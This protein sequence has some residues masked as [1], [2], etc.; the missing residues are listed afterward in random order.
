MNTKKTTLLVF[1]MMTA[2][3][4]CTAQTTE[5]IKDQG[6]ELT[7]IN[8]DARFSKSL[9]QMLVKTFFEVYPKLAKAF[10]PTTVKKVTFVI[11]TA[12]QGV[13]GTANGKVSYSAKYMSENPGDIDVVTHEVMHIVQD[14]GSS[15]GPW[16]LTEGIADYARFKFG[17]DNKGANWS[18]PAYQPGQKYDNGYRVTARFLVWIDTKIKSGTVKELD[19]QLR[20]HTFKEESWKQLT[21]KSL[22]V[23]WSQ[24]ISDPQL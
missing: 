10:N 1:L 2:V 11:D 7:V 6:Y 20:L 8:Q 21:G 24:Y 15:V 3:N 23:L 22:E 18:L 4:I 16:W 12:Y 9:K 14:Y 17:V 5:V 19:S 13:A